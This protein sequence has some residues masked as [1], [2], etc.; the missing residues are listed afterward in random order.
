[1]KEKLF[2]IIGVL[3]V[4]AFAN[5]C[6]SISKTK[7]ADN[8]T[9]VVANK[10]GYVFF[11]AAGAPAVDCVEML[12]KEGVKGDDM[13]DLSGNGEGIGLS[14]ARMSTAVEACSAWGIKE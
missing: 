7:M 6:K 5:N 14:A 4:L 12:A 3:L 9:A 2:M 11:T 10:W 8:K 13:K 1:M